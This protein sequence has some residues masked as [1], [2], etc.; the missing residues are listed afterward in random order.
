MWLMIVIIYIVSVM[1]ARYCMIVNA[2]KYFLDFGALLMCIL[3]V[4]NIMFVVA[5]ILVYF[6][7]EQVLNKVARLFFQRRK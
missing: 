5:E 7:T 1:A 3:P 2:N 4:V 6:S